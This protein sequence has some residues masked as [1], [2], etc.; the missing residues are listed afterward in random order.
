MPS[1]FA[2]VWRARTALDD[3]LD[4]FAAHGLGGMVGALLTGVFAQQSVNGVAGIRTEPS[5]THIIP[6]IIGDNEPTMALCER[7][8]E[9]GFYA[10]GIRHPSVPAGTARLRIT[11]MA[12]HEPAELDA[13]CDA[14]AAELS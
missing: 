2:L 11:P 8:L 3:S 7:L 14:I 1:H 6:V 10:Q 9:Q 5:T 13:L 12:T 4:V